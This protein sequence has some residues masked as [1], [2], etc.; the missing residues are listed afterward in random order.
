MNKKQTYRVLKDFLNET[1]YAVNFTLENDVLHPLF[2]SN[3]TPVFFLTPTVLFYRNSRDDIIHLSNIFYIISFGWKSFS[4][5]KSETPILSTTFVKVLLYLG[6]L[7]LH[8]NKEHFS[9]KT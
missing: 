2:L 8:S 5:T 6:V 1:S 4:I 7:I 9:I 3:Y